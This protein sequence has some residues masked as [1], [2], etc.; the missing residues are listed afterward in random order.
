MQAPL[1]VVDGQPATQ[2]FWPKSLHRVA[3]KDRNQK[4][5]PGRPETERQK[6]EQQILWNMDW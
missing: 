1:V 6:Y 5:R 4:L 2:Y 3:L